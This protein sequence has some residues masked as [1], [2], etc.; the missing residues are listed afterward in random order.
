MGV[1]EIRIHLVNFCSS[2]LLTH[3]TVLLD[4]LCVVFVFADHA[5]VWQ[6]TGPLLQAC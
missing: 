6:V 2:Y 5:H 1:A 3:H 4:Q